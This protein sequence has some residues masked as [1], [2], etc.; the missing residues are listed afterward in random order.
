MIYGPHRA[1]GAPQVGVLPGQEGHFG[2]RHDP[3]GDAA[4]HHNGPEVPAP[5][6]QSLLCPY[7]AAGPSDGQART[8]AAAG[9]TLTVTW[10]LLSCPH[11]VAD[12][13]LAGEED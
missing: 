5:R 12:R 9:E 3:A 10:H 11:H 1:K 7:C 6:T 13:V 8:I 4:A 2:R